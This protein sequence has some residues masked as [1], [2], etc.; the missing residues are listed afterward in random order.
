MYYVSKRMEVAAAHKLDLPYESKCKNLHGHNYIITTYCKA[1][2]LNAEGM[3]VDFA[4]VKEAIHGRLDHM[5][6]NDIFDFNPTA[7][8]MAKW[9]CDEVSEICDTGYCYKVEVQESEGNIATYE[10]E[11]E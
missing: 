7:E 4:K 6:L 3:V 2:V 5:Y 8:N 1:K 9:I 11:V 10:R